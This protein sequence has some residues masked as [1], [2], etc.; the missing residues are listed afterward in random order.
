M[1]FDGKEVTMEERK[2]VE[3]SGMIE[4]KAPPMVHFQQYPTV[5]VPVK[6][7]PVNFDGVFTNLKFQLEQPSPQNAAS[8]QLGGVMGNGMGNTH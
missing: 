6:L 7:N 8:K 3:Q 1:I 4:P 2:R 5:K